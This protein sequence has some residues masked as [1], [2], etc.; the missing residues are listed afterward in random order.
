MAVEVYDATAFT[1]EDFRVEGARSG[2]DDQALKAILRHLG[3][4]G[5]GNLLDQQVA[6]LSN[7][8]FLLPSPYSNDR[9][10][11]CSSSFFF[12]YRFY[13]L[14][15]SES[16]SDYLWISGLLDRGYRLDTLW[17]PNRNL[18]YSN[19]P[20]QFPHSLP[21]EYLLREAKQKGSEAS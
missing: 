5:E 20:S 18:A 15:C 19:Y 3:S 21:P 7:R 1:D 17:M 8:E 11:R 16:N 4:I 10:D 6:T 9:I 2:C 13:F 12:E 14:F